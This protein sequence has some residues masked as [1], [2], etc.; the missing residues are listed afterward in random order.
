LFQPVSESSS[1]RIVEQ[2]YITRPDRRNQVLGVL[3]GHGS[4]DA[5]F[6]ISQL[7]AV[8]GRAVH[9]V[10]YSLRDPEELRCAGDRHPAHVD[11]RATRVGK[12]EAQHLGHAATSRGGVDIPDHPVVQDLSRFG[13]R[14]FELPPFLLVQHVS[15]ALWR[16]GGN[17]NGL[18]DE[19]AHFAIVANSTI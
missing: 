18:G 13:E 10:V 4:V 9:E 12:E 16:K 11:T 17:L 3:C 6:F 5:C 14:L 2:D 15:Q 7:A 1:L 19:R 8:S